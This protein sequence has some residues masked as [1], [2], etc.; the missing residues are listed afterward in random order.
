MSNFK[1]SNVGSL[2]VKV[3][4]TSDLNLYFSLGFESFQ[5]SISLSDKIANSGK[6]IANVTFDA[7]YYFSFLHLI[8]SH[9]ALI[10]ISVILTF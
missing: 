5:G 9:F 2:V 7:Y 1:A 8:L 3:H 10:S 4:V 6:I